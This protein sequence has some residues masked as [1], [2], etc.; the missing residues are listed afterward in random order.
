M[1]DDAPP[2]RSGAKSKHAG[3]V[4]FVLGRLFCFLFW[5]WVIILAT[6]N[7]TASSAVRGF[8]RQRRGA[9]KQQSAPE[10]HLERERGLAVGVFSAC[11]L[12]AAC[13]S[14]PSS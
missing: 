6:L 4:G 5:V 3:A 12:R 14:N 7:S 10:A 1:A 2:R 8:S 13:A 9:L 11:E